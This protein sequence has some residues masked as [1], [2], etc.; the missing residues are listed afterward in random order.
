[1]NRTE[2]LC[3][4]WHGDGFRTKVCVTTVPGTSL[5]DLSCASCGHPPACVVYS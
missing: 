5:W 4:E 3:Q 1:M 2:A